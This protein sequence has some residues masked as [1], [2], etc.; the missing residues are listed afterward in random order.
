MIAFL[1]GELRA[2]VDIVLDAV[3]LRSHLVGADLVITGEGQLDF[4][5][6]YN[7][8]PVGVARLAGERGTPVIAISGS[9]GRGFT[10]VHEHGIAAALAITPSPMTLEESSTR[11]RELAASAA[12]QAMRL[13]SVGPRVF[14]AGR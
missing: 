12:E 10:D 4:Q 11:A 14:P 13:V 3:D 7:K 1:G 5:T 6:V 8:A 9:L 2:G